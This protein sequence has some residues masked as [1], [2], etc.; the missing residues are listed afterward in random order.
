MDNGEVKD[1]KSLADRFGGQ[2][3]P[4]KKSLHYIGM[5]KLKSSATEKFNRLNFSLKVCTSLL[6]VWWRE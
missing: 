6:P 2:A 5:G 4:C 3:V 1:G